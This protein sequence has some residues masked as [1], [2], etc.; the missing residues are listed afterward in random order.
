M[1]KVPITCKRIRRKSRKGPKHGPSVSKYAHLVPRQK[2]TYDAG[3]KMF[4][5]LPVIGAPGEIIKAGLR[6]IF[7]GRLYI[8]TE[9]VTVPDVS[10]IPGTHAAMGKFRFV[11]YIDKL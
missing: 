7:H 6:Q 10:V 2:K 9:D 5:D 1:S 11:A 4:R 3:D 8:L